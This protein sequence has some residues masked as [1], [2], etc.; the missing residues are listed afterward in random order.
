M[1]EEIVQTLL[2]EAPPRILAGL[3]PEESTV[4]AVRFE[5]LLRV[6]LEKDRSGVPDPHAMGLRI[7][8]RIMEKISEV[9]P[10]KRL[11]YIE[12]ELLS[13]E[14]SSL[15]WQARKLAE[16]ALQASPD[17]L[18][19]RTQAKAILDRIN[20][21]YRLLDE[22][23]PTWEHRYGRTLSEASLDCGFVLGEHHYS[24][25]RLGRTIEFMK[26]RGHWP[27][28]WYTELWLQK[29]DSK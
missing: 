10:T 24:S 15:D 5:R 28:A 1:N 27:P 21:L 9:P 16:Q 19:L 13:R 14:I 6:A 8:R 4:V 2:Q 29:N 17:L 26:S 23:D 7:G 20:E 25:M 12:E 18:T 22:K 3:S 11:E